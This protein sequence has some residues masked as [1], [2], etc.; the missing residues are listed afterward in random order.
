MF[1]FKSV[2]QFCRA[3]GSVR[4]HERTRGKEDVG[5]QGWKVGRLERD[6]EWGKPLEIL[7]QW[8]F[9]FL[10]CDNILKIYLYVKLQLYAYDRDST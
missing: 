2:I 3:L 7:F 5:E 8:L 4:V 10:Y 9:S 6:D 1:F